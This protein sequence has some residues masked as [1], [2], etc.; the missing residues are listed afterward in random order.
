MELGGILLD[1]CSHHTQYPSFCNFCSFFTSFLVIH[2]KNSATFKNLIS[3]T[4]FRPL[5]FLEN[6]FASLRNA[7]VGYLAE[8]GPAHKD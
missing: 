5:K 8:K 6:N 4:C 2:K 7:L 1:A 3:G